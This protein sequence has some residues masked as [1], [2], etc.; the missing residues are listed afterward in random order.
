M[1][2]DISG[3]IHDPG[4]D[5]AELL[6]GKEI[7]RMLGILEAI[8]GRLI[9]GQGP[10]AGAWINGLAGVELAGGE[11]EPAVRICHGTASSMGVWPGNIRVGKHGGGL[12]KKERTTA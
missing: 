1:F 8:R 12:I 4:V 3:R 10:A 2:K 9:Q 7:G 5:I 11:T 6:E